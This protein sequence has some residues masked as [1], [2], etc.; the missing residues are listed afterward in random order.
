MKQQCRRGGGWSEL[1]GHAL[2]G[3]TVSM[4]KQPFI[5]PRLRKRVLASKHVG[6][7][8]AVWVGV[9]LHLWSRVNLP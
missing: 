1:V 6:T 7:W 3:G 4:L 5:E 2:R 8:P 9:D